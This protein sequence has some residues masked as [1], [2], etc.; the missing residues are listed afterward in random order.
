MIGD[1]L[2]DMIGAGKNHVDKLGVYYGYAHEGELEEAGLII[3]FVQLR[4]CMI[5]L[6]HIRKVFGVFGTD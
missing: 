1:R 2:H 6:R 4:N 3:R 5:S